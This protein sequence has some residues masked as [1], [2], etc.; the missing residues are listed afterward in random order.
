MINHVICSNKLEKANLSLIIDVQWMEYNAFNL[1]SQP[2]DLIQ[3]S[4]QFDSIPI[5]FIC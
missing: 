4:I 3:I 2:L 5:N 1:D